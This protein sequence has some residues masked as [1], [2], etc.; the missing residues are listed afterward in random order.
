MAWKDYRNEHERKRR[1]NRTP[2]QIEKDRIANKIKSRR[3]YERHREELLEKARNDPKRKEQ[4]RALATVYRKKYLRP[5]N[6][7]EKLASQNNLCFLCG[8]P[9]DLTIP[10]LKP[11]YDHNHKTGQ[12]RDFLHMKCNTALGLL[13]DDPALCRKAEEYL[14][15]HKETPCP[16]DTKKSETTS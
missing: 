10:K 12:W 15:R 2:E 9:F 4:Q 14:L 16:L 8:K 3:Y 7:D 6:Y 11:H 5:A 1:A 13:E